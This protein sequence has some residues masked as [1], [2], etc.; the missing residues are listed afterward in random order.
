MS[1]WP[2]VEYEHI[3]EYFIRRPGLYTQEELFAWK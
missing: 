3:F 2:D 1:I